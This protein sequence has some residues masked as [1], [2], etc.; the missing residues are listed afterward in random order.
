[1][2]KP[3]GYVREVFVSENGFNPYVASARTGKTSEDRGFCLAMVCRWIKL[4]MQLGIEGSS[5]VLS[6][7]E[8]LHISI[9]QSGYLGL[10][11][12]HTGAMSN[13]EG[14][15]LVY[16]QAGLL[17]MWQ[18]D[19]SALELMFESMG[20]NNDYYEIG[21]PYHSLGL[22][23]RASDGALFYFD[24]NYGLYEY[25]SD[26]D[27]AVLKNI[28]FYKMTEDADMFVTGLISR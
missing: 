20:S 6:E 12:T 14:E 25:T 5:S 11:R 28:Y 21:V 8:L 27:V 17:P 1:M 7:R 26:D 18:S 19:A 22:C 16:Q 15:D 4:V 2:P 3:Q 24:P 23:R 9:V 10:A 13:K